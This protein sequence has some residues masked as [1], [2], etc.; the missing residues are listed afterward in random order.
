MAAG[1]KKQT[2]LRPIQ[3]YLAVRSDGLV[4]P[5]NAVRKNPIAPHHPPRQ[6]RG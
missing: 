3:G 5:Y 1:K 4:E 2:L 6:G